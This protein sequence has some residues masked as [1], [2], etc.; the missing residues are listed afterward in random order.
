ME[1]YT[2]TLTGEEVGAIVEALNVC[3]QKY[4]AAAPFYNK[5]LFKHKERIFIS[6]VE[7]IGAAAGVNPFEEE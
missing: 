4:I 1:K 3:E 7:K 6:I 5:E 2:I